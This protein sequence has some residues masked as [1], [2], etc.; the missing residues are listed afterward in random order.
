MVVADESAHAEFEGSMGKVAAAECI[1]YLLVED[2]I[3]HEG[4][5]RIN[6]NVGQVKR[7]LQAVD[8]GTVSCLSALRPTDLCCTFVVCRGTSC[9]GD[10]Q[11]THSG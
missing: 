5:F 2:R 10:S 6:G 8:Q 1:E 11:S 7:Y 3:G 4:L 9:R